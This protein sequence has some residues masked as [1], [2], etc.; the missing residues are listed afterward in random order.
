V[1]VNPRFG[2]LGEGNTITEPTVPKWVIEPTTPPPLPD[3]GTNQ[4]GD[5]P[6]PTPSATP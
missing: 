4:P 6:A 3:S 2:T 5:G 1:E